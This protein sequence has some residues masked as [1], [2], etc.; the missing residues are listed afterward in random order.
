MNSA[1][2][3]GS[4]FDKLFG[5]DNDN[6]GDNGW[7]TEPPAVN[8]NTDSSDPSD[9]RPDTTDDDSQFSDGNLRR[10]AGYT[11]KEFQRYLLSDVVKNLCA[12]LRQA[13][14]SGDTL[15]QACLTGT[16]FFFIKLLN[17]YYLCFK[18][19]LFSSKFEIYMRNS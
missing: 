16:R 7:S 14:A 6:A 4:F 19:N 3:T 11:P 2:K 1:K 9:P 17:Y 15:K 10:L 8:N 12:T 5:R 18:L 13:I